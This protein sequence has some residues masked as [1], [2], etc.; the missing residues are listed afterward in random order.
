[1]PSK[2]Q[3]AGALL[4][5]EYREKKPYSLMKTELAPISD[6]EAYDIQKE[7]MLLRAQDSGGYSGYKIAYTTK[8]MQERVGAS[9]PVFGRILS[10]SVH[11]SPASLKAK[12]YVNL[13]VECEVAVKM[14][15]NL[16]VKDE[17]LDRDSIFEA[18]EYLQL[19]FE[20][21]DI[22]QSLA[23]NSLIQSI[24]TNIHG[25]GV[26]LGEPIRNWRELDI[27]SATC[28][29]KL[30]GTSVGTGCA[31]DVNGHPAE[32]MVWIANAL[33][34]RKRHLRAGDLVITGSMI[35]PT[36]LQAGTSA[37]LEMDNLGSVSLLVE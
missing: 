1:M 14:G 34:S 29:L 11:Q 16:E 22:R 32:P 10:D 12:N 18:I 36:F 8:V 4:Y 5:R 24:A 2:S 23:E 19:A 13:A 9:E 25:A 17:G 21:V 26:V 31:S 37:L 33:L 3:Q 6:S 30:D 35:P 20:L 15:S 7:F 28:E 27:P